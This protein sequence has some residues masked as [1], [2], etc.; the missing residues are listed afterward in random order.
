MKKCTQEIDKINEKIEQLQVK[1]REIELG[2]KLSKF[3]FEFGVDITLH[4][5]QIWP[6]GDAPENP[7]VEDVQELLDDLGM[8]ATCT[9]N[10]WNLIRRDEDEFKI[11]KL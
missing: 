1:K 9:I 4:E 8:S 10:E 7:T 3:R 6:D 11:T 5:D 2:R